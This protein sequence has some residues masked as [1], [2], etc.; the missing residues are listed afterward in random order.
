MQTTNPEI[1]KLKQTSFEQSLWIASIGETETG[2]DNGNFALRIDIK[3]TNEVY[4]KDEKTHEIN[5]YDV[6]AV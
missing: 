2:K 5:H 3:K 6:T 1:E 4:E